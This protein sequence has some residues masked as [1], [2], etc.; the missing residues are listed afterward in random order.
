M[1]QTIVN[2]TCDVCGK[3]IDTK[4]PVSMGLI[5]IAKI[6][7]Q[8]GA[9]NEIGKVPTLNMT[10][11]MVDISID[12]CGECVNKVEEFINSIKK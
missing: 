11:K 7:P 6:V 4:N 1:R 9:L 3:E 8:L 5:S 2:I 12:M 10:Q